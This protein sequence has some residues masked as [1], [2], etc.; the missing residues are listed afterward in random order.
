MTV[1]ATIS[2]DELNQFT[3]S[4]STGDSGLVF[5]VREDRL[6]V[7]SNGL[8][9]RGIPL[10]VEET[11]LGQGSALN[12][13]SVPQSL[14]DQLLKQERPGPLRP[15]PGLRVRPERTRKGRKGRIRGP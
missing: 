8:R 2:E 4:K 1:D 3:N 6:L 9:G 10:R 12:C 7:A 14:R 11:T 5:A 13:H 15:R